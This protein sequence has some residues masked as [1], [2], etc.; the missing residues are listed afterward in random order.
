MV[1]VAFCGCAPD[2]EESSEHKFLREGLTP[3][4]TPAQITQFENNAPE[5]IYG[6]VE[7]FPPA[8][9]VYNTKDQVKY[10]NGFTPSYIIP[11]CDKRFFDRLK[12]L[13]TTE[14]R[15]RESM[16]TC[17]Q[18]EIGDKLDYDRFYPLPLSRNWADYHSV[19][20]LCF[21]RCINGKRRCK[22]LICK[23][24]ASLYERPHKKWRSSG[25]WH[26]FI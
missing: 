4:L 2:G 18:P 3:P 22:A 10:H 1:A 16:L 7:V 12:V 11:I 5:I 24:W 6:T 26:F 17:T 23:Q 19:F 21:S 20:L 9:G 13:L 8:V 15:V 14:R 25:E